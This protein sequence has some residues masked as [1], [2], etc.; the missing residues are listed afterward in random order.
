LPRPGEVTNDLLTLFIALGV[1]ALVLMLVAFPSALF[2]ETLEENYDRIFGWLNRGGAAGAVMGMATAMWR[3]PPGL[4]L[5]MFLSA[6]IYGFLEPQFGLDLE[7][8]ALVIGIAA[9]LIITTATFEYPLT[10]FQRRANADRGLIRVLPFSLVVAVLC[11]IAS[12]VAGFEPGYIF[13]VIAFWTFS[14]AMTPRAEGAS[15]AVTSVFILLLALAAW[16]ALPFADGLLA[17]SPLAHVAVAAALTTIF[18]GGLQGLLFELFPLR[19]LRGSKLWDWS[20]PVWLLIFFVAAFAF[21]HVLV[22]PNIDFMFEAGGSGLVVAIAFLLTFTIISIAFWAYFRRH[23]PS[24]EPL[25]VQ[26][27]G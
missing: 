7:S 2:E 20:K 14:R 6:V 21:V 13:G 18:I 8:I 15:V 3:S 17:S 9:G 25:P 1:A 19:F 5:F 22:V 16:L 24:A 11:V 10:L 23:Q 4:A 27:D 26:L 12:R